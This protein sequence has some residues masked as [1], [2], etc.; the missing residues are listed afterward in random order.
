MTT[1]VMDVGG[2]DRGA[3]GDGEP[4]WCFYFRKKMLA[5][6]TGSNGSYAG[7]LLFNVCGTIPHKNPSA[8][9]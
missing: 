8:F 2:V 6:L 4:G 7:D 9:V 5:Q 1:H 3:N